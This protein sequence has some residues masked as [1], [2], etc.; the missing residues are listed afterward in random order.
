[1]SGNV[2]SQDFSFLSTKINDSSSWLMRGLINFL[3]QRPV[4]AGEEIVV[5]ADEAQVKCI[6]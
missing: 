4:L 1:M 5:K 6:N 3:S 2:V